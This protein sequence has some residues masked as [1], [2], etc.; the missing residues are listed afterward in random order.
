MTKI[1]LLPWRLQLADEQRKQFLGLLLASIVMVG[2][3][4]FIAFFKVN[5]K[6]NRTKKVNQYIEQQTSGLSQQLTQ[7]QEIKEQREELIV[8]SQILQHLQ[9]KR[10]A[11]VHLLEDIALKLP[12]GVFLTEI[13]KEGAQLTLRG[14][15]ESN[16]RVSELMQ[17]I[18]GSEWI[19]NPLLTEIKSEEKVNASDVDSNVRDFEIRMT[20]KLPSLAELSREEEDES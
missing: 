7:I 17:R 6:L 3:M 2:S 1:N 13:K 5:N 12:E 8:R 19:S 14:K 18:E 20:Q 15:A 10:I 9:V 16:T 11:L 4:M